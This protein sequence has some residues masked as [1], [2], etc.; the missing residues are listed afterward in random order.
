MAPT[1]LEKVLDGVYLSMAPVILDAGA[2]YSA[3]CDALLALVA[4]VETDQRG[5]AG[6]AVGD[7]AQFLRNGGNL[8]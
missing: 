1:Q 2:D 3:A 6:T 4:E 5:T 7:N 8:D